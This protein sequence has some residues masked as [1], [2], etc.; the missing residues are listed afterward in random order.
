VPYPCRYICLSSLCQRAQVIPFCDA[1]SGH[2]LTV[3][4]HAVQKVT[5]S[6]P[7]LLTCWPLQAHQGSTSLLTRHISCP[8]WSWKFSKKASVVA[9]RAP[10]LHALGLT[11]HVYVA[12]C[13]R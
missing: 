8:S 5:A 1:M 7:T 3:A 2:H 9:R 13:V 4:Q 12:Q 11:L 6:L 10:L